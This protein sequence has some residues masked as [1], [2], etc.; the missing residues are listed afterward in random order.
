MLFY[1]QIPNPIQNWLHCQASLNSPQLVLKNV[2]SG[3]QIKVP[4]VW[5]NRPNPPPSFL[6]S[7]EY[8]ESFS[9][10]QM[11]RKGFWR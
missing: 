5:Y 1:Q 11:F 2:L 9:D 4:N 10:Q 7:K 8:Y 3:E 6:T